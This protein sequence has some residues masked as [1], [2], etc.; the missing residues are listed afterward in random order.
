VTLPLAA[1]SYA[2]LQADTTCWKCGESTRVTTIWVA[3]FTDTSDVEGPEDEPEIGGAATLHHTPQVQ[4]NWRA[5][6]P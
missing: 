6:S 2:L 4:N 3:S 1:P 5:L